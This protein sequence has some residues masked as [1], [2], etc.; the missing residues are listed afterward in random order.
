MSKILMGSSFS[1]LLA[2]MVRKAMKDF[3]FSDGTF[4]PKGGFVSAASMPTHHDDEIY[5]NS[6]TFNPWRFADLR[7]EEG[8][9]LKHQ[10]VSTS[11][12]FLSFGHGK[13]AW[14]VIILILSFEHMHLPR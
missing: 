14:Y 2:S 11:T 7:E 5:S 6:S 4:I 3:R 1:V 13:H 12:K 8:E 9:E 10:M